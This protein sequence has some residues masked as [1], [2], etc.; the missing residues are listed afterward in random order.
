MWIKAAFR[1]V[2]VLNLLLIS[3]I[4]IF[5]FSVLFPLVTAE[6]KYTLPAPKPH[7]HEEQDQ[8]GDD[9]E[10]EEEFSETESPSIGLYGVVSEENLFHPERAIPVEKKAEQ[11]LPKPDFVL[12]GTLITDNLGIAYIEDRKAPRST[13]G[14]GKRQVALRKGESLSGFALKEIE[15]GQIVMV[16]GEEKIVVPI[17]DPAHPRE[18]AATAPPPA[19]TPQQ[20]PAPKGREV[21]RQGTERRIP[22]VRPS[23]R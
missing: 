5:S 4:A 13:S 22:P 17:I 23:T 16:R 6:I 11:P 12:Y 21:I 20:K 3:A 8:E 9:E 15:A 2:N 7:V 10:H 19:V 1:N 14:R 18:N